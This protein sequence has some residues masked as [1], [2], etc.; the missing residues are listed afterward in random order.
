[1]IEKSSAEHRMPPRTRPTHALEGDRL[2]RR[3]G[4]AGGLGASLIAAMEALQALAGHLLVTGGMIHD[5]SNRREGEV[6]R[7]GP[8]LWGRHR[9][10]PRLCLGWVDHREH[11]PTDG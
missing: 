7:V 5:T 2:C 11:D 8:N 3:R 9:H 1:M 6:W 4:V 10:D